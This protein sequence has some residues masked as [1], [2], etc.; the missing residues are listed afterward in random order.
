MLLNGNVR[1]PPALLLVNALCAFALNLAVFLLIGKT[2]ALTM[3]IAGVIKDWLLIWFSFTVFQAPV[4]A[5]NLAGYVFCCAG[6]FVYNYLKLQKMK[7]KEKGMLGRKLT[8]DLES[9]RGGGRGRIR[10]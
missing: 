3:N 8:R 9:Q 5:L 2:S 10:A 7:M 4:T 6:V 1:F